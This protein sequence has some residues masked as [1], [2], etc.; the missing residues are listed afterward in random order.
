MDEQG[1]DAVWLFPTLGVLY[2]Q[3]LKTDPDAAVVAFRS[4]N[5]WLEEDWGLHYQDRIFGAPYI[6]LADVDEAVSEF[7]WA[8]DRG[9]RLVC[10][11]PA[12][13]TTKIGPRSPGDRCS[14][15]SGRG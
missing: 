15:R 9:A 4:F 10:M 13:P 3:D 2:E 14:I 5:R 7:E 6:T 8:L 11:R 1:L 12:A